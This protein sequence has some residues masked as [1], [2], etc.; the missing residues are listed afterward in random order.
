MSGTI[1][2]VLSA[3]IGSSL[4]SDMVKWISLTASVRAT[5]QSIYKKCDVMV[6]QEHHCSDMRLEMHEA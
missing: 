2:M 4:F 3:V 1:Q 5:L 6:L